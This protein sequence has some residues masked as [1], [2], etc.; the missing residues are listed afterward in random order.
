[1]KDVAGAL[2]LQGA[3][4]QKVAGSMLKAAMHDRDDK[5]LAA[6]VTKAQKS[7]VDTM[8][9]DYKRMVNAKLP[10]AAC[11]WLKRFDADFGAMPLTCAL[12]AL[13]SGPNKRLTFTVEVQVN[14]KMRKA[15][16]IYTCALK[17]ALPTWL[18]SC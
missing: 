12:A 1:M 18:W 2:I 6:L 5:L 3:D 14:R 4:I 7:L 8:D 10:K 9:V 17:T 16:R 15:I 11:A 13:M